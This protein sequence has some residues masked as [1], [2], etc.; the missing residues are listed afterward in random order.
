MF[1]QIS[2]LSMHSQFD[3]NY[4]VQLQCFHIYSDGKFH[5]EEYLLHFIFLYLTFHKY[6]SLLNFSAIM[7]VVMSD[8]QCW[9]DYLHIVV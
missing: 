8:R 1:R 6:S 7:A 4:N 9:V 5:F 2:M 3:C